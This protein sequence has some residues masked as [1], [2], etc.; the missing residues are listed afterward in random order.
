MK[1]YIHRHIATLAAATTITFT[2]AAQNLSESVTV[3]GRY[4]P[5]VIQA[6]RLPVAPSVIS[7]KA[8][9]SNMT[10]DR[11]GVMADFAPD[12]LSMSATGWRATKNYNNSRGYVDVRLGSWLNSSLSAGVN[13]FRSPDTQANVWLQHNSTSLWKAWNAGDMYYAD[14]D[15]RFRYDETI[16][17]D[18]CHHITDIG[19]ISATLQYHLG[20]FNYYATHHGL[21]ENGHYPAPT[22]TLNDVAARVAWKGETSQNVSY[23]A[24]ADVRYFGYRSMYLPTIIENPMVTKGERESLVNLEAN[25]AYH[26]AETAKIGI[27]VRYSGVFNQIGSNVNRMELLPAYSVAGNL[28]SVKVG[29]NVAF[30]NTETGTRFRAAPDIMLGI[31]KGITSVSLSLGGGTYLRTMAW[32]HTMDYY[33]NPSA[34]C[35][36]AAYSPIDAK[37]ALQ[38]NPGGKWT[39]GV[40]GM[41]RATLDETSGGLYQLMLNGGLQNVATDI[42]SSRLHGMSIAINAGYEFSRFL[43]L[44]G[45]GTWQPQHG[46]VGILN[47]FDRPVFTAALSAESRPVDAL[48]L[49]LDYN[50]RARRLLLPGNLSRIN[51]GGAYRITERLSVSAEIDNLLNRHEDLFPGLPTEG[52]AATAG[53]QFVF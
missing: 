29:A 33:A 10:Y 53:I 43:R 14:A 40:E 42:V 12:A 16:G 6:D 7:L 51:L 15:R 19:T 47:G 9:E 25:A 26:P 52:L 37:V 32:R 18:F 44:N 39:F 11:T 48:T 20:Y 2:G 49:R 30:V 13:V 8:P 17:A 28:F 35:Y 5:E 3:E 1:R 22:Q 34:G 45:R 31:R 41:W 21:A 27:D 23:G 36:E 50:L 46:T 4:T 24:K 38:F